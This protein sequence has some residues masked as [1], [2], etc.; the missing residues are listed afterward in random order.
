MNLSG[1]YSRWDLL[2]INVR[3]EQ[4]EPVVPMEPSKSMSMIPES[5]YIK[6]LEIKIKQLEQQIAAFSKEKTRD[7]S[8]KITLL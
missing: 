4:Y 7:S 8:D 5:G 1:I 3:Q 6:D 2:N